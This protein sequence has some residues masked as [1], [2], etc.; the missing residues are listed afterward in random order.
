[1]ISLRDGVERFDRFFLR[2]DAAAPLALFR[3]LF[4]V[5]VFLAV[6]ASLGDYDYWVGPTSIITPEVNRRLTGPTELTFFALVAPTSSSWIFFLV[7]LL[8]ASIT[9]IVSSLTERLWWIP[10]A[11]MGRLAT[12]WIYIGF[13]TF[14]TEWPMVLNGCDSLMRIT[15]FLLIFSPSVTLKTRDPASRWA[16]RLIQIQ[17][18]VLYLST[19][20]WKLQGPK[21]QD[22]TAAFWSIQY[23]SLKRF[24]ENIIFA[25]PDWAQ[26]ILA[27]V[28][29][30][31]AFGVEFLFCF[32]VFF[33]ETRRVMLVFTMLLHLSIAIT[34]RLVFFEW[35]MVCHLAIF[36][37]HEE[38]RW[39]VKK[40]TFGRVEIGPIASTSASSAAE[41]P[42]A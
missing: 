37:T 26:E 27:R 33:R 15:S 39:L 24:D 25:A 9:L 7:S 42:Q 2:T 17:L 16:K 30:W 11:P 28:G 18:C 13:M 32:L 21:W 8:V 40:I 14:S 10:L 35:V 12:V 29:T 1:M 3:L 23:P 31:G 41:S 36:L 22:G 34:M 38:V 4:G 5:C 6:T 19:A 20:L